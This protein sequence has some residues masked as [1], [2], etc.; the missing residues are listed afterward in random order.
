MFEF[1]KQNLVMRIIFFLV[2]IKIWP[3]IL[4]LSFIVISY[5]NI[6]MPDAVITWLFSK[7]SIKFFCKYKHFS[8][9]MTYLFFTVYWFLPILKPALLSLR[10]MQNTWNVIIINYCEKNTEKKGY[11]QHKLLKP[12][13]YILLHH[14][15]IPSINL[16]K[17]MW[18]EEYLF[19]ATAARF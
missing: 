16:D 18:L 4:S 19:I 9:D 1:K 7:K 11:G 3:I 2:S 10:R 6:M 14:V 17:D 5:V 12:D 8:W 15:A 13:F